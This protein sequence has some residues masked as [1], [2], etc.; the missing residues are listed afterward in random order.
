METWL[1]SQIPKLFDKNK[2][3]MNDNEATEI[4]AKVGHHLSKLMD[5]ILALITTQSV[6]KD[7]EAHTVLPRHVQSSLEYVQKT[8]YPKEHTQKG[9]KQKD[10]S[11]VMLS[12]TIIETTEYK[13]LFPS[14]EIIKRLMDLGL[15]ISKHTLDIVKRVLNMH[16][17]CLIMDF[18]E[19]QPITLKKVEKIFQLKR[20]QVF[21]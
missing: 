16:V 3:S 8:C 15:D 10:E 1:T 4:Y 18:H 2:I 17:N 19:Q 21:H 12:Y 13:E 20:H 5:N 6:I 14:I 7:P 9:G 11:W